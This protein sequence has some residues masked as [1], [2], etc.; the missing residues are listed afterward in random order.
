MCNKDFRKVL[1]RFLI[2]LYKHNI[3]KGRSNHDQNNIIA[4]ELINAGWT[5]TDISFVF[6]SIYNEPAGNYG[7]Y[8]DDPNKAGWQINTMRKKEMQRYSLQK[9]KEIGVG[10]SEYCPCEAS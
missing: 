5:D 6:R 9:V 7:W 1:H 2:Y 3:A 4:A 8:N 10:C